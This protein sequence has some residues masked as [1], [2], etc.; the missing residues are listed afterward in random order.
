MLPIT[1]TI[2]AAVIAS[3]IPSI[4]TIT[5]KVC[6]GVNEFFIIRNLSADT[7]FKF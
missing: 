7:I 2:V 3:I 6:N 5:I 1:N 4:D